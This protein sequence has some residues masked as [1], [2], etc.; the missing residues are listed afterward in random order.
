MPYSGTSITIVIS[1]LL[2]VAIIIGLLL[3]PITNRIVRRE[4]G[5]TDDQRAEVRVATRDTLLKAA[6]GFVLLLGAVGTVGTL[7]YTAQTTRASQNE[8]KSAENEASIAGY[9]QV[10]S[11]YATAIDQLSSGNRDERL[12][13]I[14]ALEGVMREAHI[15]QPAVIN[16]LCDFVRE[17]STSSNP[18]IDILAALE[19][20]SRRNPNWDSNSIDLDGAHLDNAELDGAHFADANLSGAFMGGIQLVS[21][22]L[23][24]ADL[25]SADISGANLN[26]ANLEDANL[27]GGA[28]LSGTT[29]WKADLRGADLQNVDLS[30]ASL[31]DADLAMTNLR[32]ANLKGADLRGANLR[33]V[34]GLTQ[35]Q[36]SEAK[37]DNATQ[38]PVGYKV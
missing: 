34:Y 6:G 14:Y 24:R 15:D 27:N 5:L 22:D 20:I 33:G 31:E 1:V 4:Q 11:S 36:I 32:N 13:G 37:L 30:G 3:G 18:A 35:Q 9:G 10:T 29:L 16:V 7:I 26:G 28:S 23:R 17:H 8:A 2:L 38:L 21:A 25:G 19:V 12:G